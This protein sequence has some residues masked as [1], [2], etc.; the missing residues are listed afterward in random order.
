MEQDNKDK[1]SVHRRT[2]IKLTA[3]TGAFASLPETWTKPIVQSVI[4]PAHAQ[5]SPLRT[6]DHDHHGPGARPPPDCDSVRPRLQPPT[7]T[8]PP[9]TTT[10]LRS[11]DQASVSDDNSV[12]HKSR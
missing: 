10:A 6:A 11:D 5:T 3:G 4:L 7:T 1:K 9:T 2:V 12:S 8:E